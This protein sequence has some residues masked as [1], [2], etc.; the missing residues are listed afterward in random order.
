MVRLLARHLVRLRFMS[1][2]AFLVV[3]VVFGAQGVRNEMR[4]DG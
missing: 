3:V 2:S 1:I 4:D